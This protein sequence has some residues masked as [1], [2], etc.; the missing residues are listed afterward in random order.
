M[1]KKILTFLLIISLCFLSGCGKNTTTQNSD[2]DT[3]TDNK[4]TYVVEAIESAKINDT[5]KQYA[6]TLKNVSKNDAIIKKIG[7]GISGSEDKILY[8]NSQDT[9]I[10]FLANKE[11]V[12]R[13]VIDNNDLEKAFFIS[14]FYEDGSLM[15]RSEDEVVTNDIASYITKASIQNNPDNA[16]LSVTIHNTSGNDLYL[17]TINAKTLDDNNLPLAIGYFDAN[18]TLKN[19][20]EKTYELTSPSFEGTPQLIE[21][22]T[23]K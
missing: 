4:V 23:N 1:K 13:C 20:E 3:T 18:E 17:N 5:Q 21:F 2:N 16:I 9:N 22:Y 6:I 10:N 19:D 14:L 8:V 7:Y 11:Y 15:D 12:Y